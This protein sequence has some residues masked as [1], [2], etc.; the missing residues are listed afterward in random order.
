MHFIHR[1]IAVG[2]GESSVTDTGHFDCFRT[3]SVAGNVDGAFFYL[4]PLLARSS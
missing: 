3:S 4:I 1:N 2:F